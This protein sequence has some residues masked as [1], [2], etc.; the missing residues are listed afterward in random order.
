[1]RALAALAL[2]ILAVACS[3]DGAGEGPGSDGGGGGAIECPADLAGPALVAVPSPGGTGACID[4][5]EVTMVQYQAFLDAEPAL[6]PPERCGENETFEPLADAQCDGA[7]D[8]AERPDHPVTCVDWCDA[9]SYCAWAGK[10]LCGRIGG[11]P[12][13]DAGDENDPSEAEWFNACSGMGENEYAYGDDYEI[14]TCNA[15]PDTFDYDVPPAEVGSFPDCHGTEPPFDRL[16]DMS[17]NVAEWIDS[18]DDGAGVAPYC[19]QASAG[20]TG[21]SLSSCRASAYVPWDDSFWDKGF[22]CCA[23][24]A[25]P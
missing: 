16:F 11:G 17:G 2:V 6:E 12:L 24:P 20:S 10:H 21:R 4:S 22:R 9:W 18:C 8:L 14:E 13:E 1:M 15:G 23:D 5:T 25:G 3:D 7:N 19:W